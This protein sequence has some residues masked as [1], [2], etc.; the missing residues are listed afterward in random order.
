MM[1]VNLLTDFDITIAAAIHSPSP[2]KFTLF[3]RLLILQ[4]G[5]CVYFGANVTR[6]WTT[7]SKILRCSAL[8][9][10]EFEV[11][12]SALTVGALELSELEMMRSALIVRADDQ[13][14][15]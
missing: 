13:Q 10:I 7:S 8:E 12:R 5:P 14:C 3:D 9:L 15:L 2:L 1:V 4:R 6:W 11:M